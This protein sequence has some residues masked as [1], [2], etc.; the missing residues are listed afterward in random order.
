LAASSAD[1]PAGGLKTGAGE[2]LVRLTER[3]DYGKQFAEL[4]ILVTE[5]GSKVLLRDIARIDDSFADTDRFSRYNGRNAVM[6]EV[7][8]IGNETPIQVADSVREQL[9]EFVPYMPPGIETA[10]DNDRSDIYRQRVQLL[11]KNGAFGLVLVLVLL[12][13]FL[14]AR[15][16]FWVM[17]GIPISFMGSFLLL[18]TVGVTIN[19]MSL[20]AYIIALGIVVDDAI[21]VGENFY[22]YR[23][24]GLSPMAAA[25]KGVGEVSVPVVF[26]ILTN[27]AAFLPIYFI[28]GVTGNIFRMIPVVVCVVFYDFAAGMHFHVLPAHLGHEQEADGAP[29]SPDGFMHGS[30]GFSNWIH[31]VGLSP[32]MARCCPCPCETSL[33]DDSFCHEPC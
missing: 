16:A 29:V 32:V 1:I 27:I 14:E 21:V 18:P 17:M 8:R 26:S 20:F 24:Q 33:F 23:Q 30:K 13:L 3:R 2:V 22:Y 19:M 25:I 4:P 9:K 11:L 6:L 10:I 31:L 5:D 28:P 15:L 7:Y 12:G